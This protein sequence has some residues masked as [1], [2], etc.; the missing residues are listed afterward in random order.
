MWN[1]L[2]EPGRVSAPSS[3]KFVSRFTPGFQLGLGL[4]LE[5]RPCWFICAPKLSENMGELLHQ[6]EEQRVL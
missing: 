2:S 4:K 3:L 5:S 6:V 1:S